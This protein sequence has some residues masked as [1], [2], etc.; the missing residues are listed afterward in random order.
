M[1]NLVFYFKNEAKFFFEFTQDFTFFLTEY[2]FYLPKKLPNALPTLVAK[3]APRST[4]FRA[5]EP[6]AAKSLT[7]S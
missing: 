6:T 7:A 1:F 5:P 3:P 4:K 2:L